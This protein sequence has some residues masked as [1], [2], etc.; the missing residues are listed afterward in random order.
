MDCHCLDNVACCNHH[1]LAIWQVTLSPL[2]L[3][4]CVTPLSLV[5]TGVVVCHG[6]CVRLMAAESGGGCW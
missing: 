2:V 3:V 4:M 1:V 5:C 6:G